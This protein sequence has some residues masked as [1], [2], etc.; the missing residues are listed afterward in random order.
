[1][2]PMALA[3]S[4]NQTPIPGSSGRSGKINQS[5]LPLTIVVSLSKQR[6]VAYRGTNVVAS[7]RI[8]SGKAGHRTPKGVFSI[9]QKRRRHYSNLYANAPMPFMQRVTWSGIALHAGHIPGYPASHGCIRL[10][11]R[12]ARKLFSITSMAD[13]VIITNGSPTPKTF[14]HD[15]LIKPL[16]PGDPTTTPAA[17][18]SSDTP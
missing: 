2:P 6:L 3:Q 15:G 14:A 17:V 8:S 18:A 11:Y 13:R 10:P 1:M 12:F 4:K 9:L 5:Q 16:P 7:S